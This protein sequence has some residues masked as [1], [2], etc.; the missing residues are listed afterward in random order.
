MLYAPE[1]THLVHVVLSRTPEQ[2][3]RVV[4]SRGAKGESVE[5]VLCVGKVSRLCTCA[6]SHLNRTLSP[7]ALHW[8]LTDPNK[9]GQKNP[10]EGVGLRTRSLEPTM[11]SVPKELPDVRLTSP[12]L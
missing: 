7:S 6:K 11:G 10:L 12:G 1:Y 4:L 3:Q 8:M 2:S 5:N 9:K